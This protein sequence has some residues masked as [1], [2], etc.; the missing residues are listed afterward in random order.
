MNLKIIGI[1]F[2]VSL[3]LFVMSAASTISLLNKVFAKAIFNKNNNINIQGGKNI[4]TILS[5]LFGT[6]TSS[7]PP[8]SESTE[9]YAPHHH[10]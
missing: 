3:M 5:T 1:A 7:S 2:I 10:K 4:G 9:N 8:T 6:P